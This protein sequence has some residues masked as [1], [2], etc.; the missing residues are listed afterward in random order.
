MDGAALGGQV[1]STSYLQAAV[2]ALWRESVGRPKLTS[3]NCGGVGP[4]IRAKP[5][6]APLE[7]IL[8]P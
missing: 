7:T 8:T 5:Q 6:D 4:P 2:Q 3:G 1:G